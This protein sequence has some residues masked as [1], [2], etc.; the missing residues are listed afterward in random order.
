[1]WSWH[2]PEGYGHA[3]DM[4]A[5][6][7]SL[8]EAVA[9]A[10]CFPLVFRTTANGPV[11]QALLRRAA[12]GRSVFIGQDGQWQASWLPLRLAAWPFDLVETSAGG[13]ALALN[14]TSDC[15]YDGPRGTPIFASGDGATLSPETTRMAAILKAQAEDLPATTRAA[16]ALHDSGLLTELDGDT[17]LSV[18]DPHL[19]AGLNEAGV[20]ALHRAGALALLYAGLVSLSH[21][22]WMGKAE[23]LLAT[24]SS[25]HRAQPL[26]DRKPAAAGSAF[27]AAIAAASS[28]EEA[29]IQF[30]GPNQ[31]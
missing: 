15:V 16:A 30:P 9:A 5:V 17:S 11:L 22:S 26:P 29:Q 18:I 21:L 24:A 12:K 7:V 8:T 6:P 31:L 4:R 25:H 14:E 1:M 13:H 23:R 28:A 3:R 27:L 2:R 10:A 19:A 20:M